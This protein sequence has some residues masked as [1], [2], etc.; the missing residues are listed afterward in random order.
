M[1]NELIT[2]LPFAE[3]LK[4][5]ALSKSL[6][7]EILRSPAHL[8][9]R[10][11]TPIQV[12]VAM[13]FGSAVDCLV[14]DGQ[15]AFDAHYIVRPEGIDLRTKAGKAW[16]AEAGGREIVS[17]KVIDCAHAVMEYGPAAKLMGQSV[18]QSSYVWLDEETGTW[19]KNRPDF[20]IQS[21]RA[22]AD[23]KTT[24]DADADAFGRKAVNLRYAW[25]AA[26]YLDG[27]T[28][29]TGKVHDRFFFIVAE[30]EPPH[31]VEVYELGQAE[32]EMGR[33]EYRAALALYAQC[34]KNNHWP[35][36]SGNV[37]TLSFP[38]WA[39]K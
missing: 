10:K 30:R 8:Q 18:A 34:E 25:Q 23:L 26:M 19:I 33:E 14:T 16:K 37:N 12:T 20:H 24:D 32:I 22:L 6:L 29:V 11:A 27:A 28:A 31:R 39:F 4:L 1:K 13:Q 36:S 21:L 5:P 38:G 15:A 35:A 17:Q 7:V 2:D 3:Y 9:H